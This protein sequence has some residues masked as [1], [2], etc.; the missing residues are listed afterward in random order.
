MKASGRDSKLR[1]AIDGRHI[2]ARPS[3]IGWYT[4][5][6]A[7]ELESLGH[8]PIL[9]G[10]RAEDLAA[11]AP[12]GLGPKTSPVPLSGNYLSPTGHLRLLR[13]LGSLEADLYHCP[14]IPFPYFW[15]RIPKVVTIHDL[16]PILFPESV[17]GSLKGR[18][19]GAFHWLHRRAIRVADRIITVSAHTA[20]DVIR[21]FPEA[22]EKITVVSNGV[23][24]SD[25]LDDDVV[26]SQLED[27]G[28]HRP[29]ILYVGRRDPYKRVDL[30]VRA[31]AR[32][33]DS[34]N[35]QLVLVGQPD[36]R[37]PHAE[38]ALEETG[39][40][41]RVTVLGYVA[42]RSLQALYQGAQFVA[43]PSA[44][45]GFGLPLLEAMAAGTSVLACRAASIPEV[46]GDAAH[47]V[48]PDN[49]DEL[50]GG[51]LELWENSDL[52]QRLSKAGLQRVHEFTWRRS[53]EETARVYAEAVSKTSAS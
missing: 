46:V 48:E 27:L 20:K 43:H 31:F 30:L 25:L 44:Y 51:I 12:D 33:A 6:L 5:H 47:L 34:V 16:I 22:E 36:P 52:R 40:H 23:L 50:T 32:V 8:E 2:G 3:G 17:R 19:P 26:T 18:F 41:S 13:L 45:E 1:I 28:V 21:L 15:K 42:G 53:A 4:L 39:I 14:Y 29:Y 11:A 49:L 38:R 9:I 10:P 37:F 35:G 7:R 24:I